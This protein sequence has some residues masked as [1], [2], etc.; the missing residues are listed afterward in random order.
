ME[1]GS[2]FITPENSS[3]SIEDLVKALLTKDEDGRWA[4]RT[5]QVSAGA[6][7]AIDCNNGDISLEDAFRKTIGIND[8]GKPAIRMAV[9]I[10]GS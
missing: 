5:M 4:F 8:S 2:N 10:V 9:L 1:T 6:E 7:S 3:I